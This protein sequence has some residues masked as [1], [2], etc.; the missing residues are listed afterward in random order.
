MA[1]VGPEALVR[2]LNRD[3]RESSKLR[4]ATKLTE[5]ARNDQGRKAVIKTNAI[6]VLIKLLR[7]PSRDLRITSSHAICNIAITKT[8]HPHIAKYG[9][10]PLLVKQILT[11]TPDEVSAGGF[12]LANL[13]RVQKLATMILEEMGGVVALANL[14]KEWN[15]S[16]AREPCGDLLLKLSLNSGI[17]DEIAKNGGIEALVQLLKDDEIRL[18]LKEK[19]LGALYNACS[20]NQ[21][22]CRRAAKAGAIS[23]IVHIMQNGSANGRFSALLM[24]KSFTINELEQKV[25]DA[26]GVETVASL[27]DCDLSGLQHAEPTNF[28][29]EV[30]KTLYE[31]SVGR[32]DIKERIAGTGVIPKLVGLLDVHNNHLRGA[33]LKLLYGLA[34]NEKAKRTIVMAGASRKLV[35][36]LERNGK[37]AEFAA[38]AVR[39]LVFDNEK[40]SA[41]LVKDGAVPALLRVLQKADRKDARKQ[42]LAALVNLS[43]EPASG[44]P[45]KICSHGGVQAFAEEVMRN[46]FSDREEQYQWAAWCAVVLHNLMEYEDCLR[47][48]WDSVRRRA[49][50]TPGLERINDPSG[51]EQW[52]SDL[53]ADSDLDYL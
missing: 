14:I 51:C 43:N 38:T 47:P 10:I 48:V 28:K 42:A 37:D 33:V 23:P 16:N 27:L 2:I 32:E 7:S 35:N 5:Y 18:G 50:Q 15:H 49:S 22:Y 30:A 8:T 25:F 19:A 3:S 39:N 12:A 17:E 53:A 31:L 44:G 52:L 46:C 20:T 24:T 1:D 9:G 40:T 29:K 41:A 4:A 11:G 6:P 34:V 45:E 26:G 36:F 21:G 13:A